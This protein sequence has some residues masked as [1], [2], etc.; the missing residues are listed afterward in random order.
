MNMVTTENM[1]VY[2]SLRYK[3]DEVRCGVFF[4]QSKLNVCEQQ[5]KTSH[6][7]KVLEVN[8]PEKDQGGY[9]HLTPQIGQIWTVTRVH[10][11]LLWS[12]V[13]NFVHVMTPEQI[14][15]GWRRLWD[16]VE[17]LQKKLLGEAWV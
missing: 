7:S 1:G 2:L 14:L 8:G 16:T 12:E 15:F 3:H 17:K 10:N 13:Q 9:S 11:H 6:S 4:N 5:T